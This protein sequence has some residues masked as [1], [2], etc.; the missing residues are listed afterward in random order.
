ME[1]LVGIALGALLIIGA[2]AVIAPALRGNQRVAQVQTETQL[3]YQLSQNVQAWAAGNW[4]NIL[5]LATGTSNAYYLNAS[6]SPFIVAGNSTT[7]GG[8]SATFG[9]TVFGTTTDNNS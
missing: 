6:S 1:V 9:Q 3:A 4:N 7:S 5:A 8:G 2:V